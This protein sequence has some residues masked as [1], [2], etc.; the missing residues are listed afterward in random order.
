MELRSFRPLIILFMVVMVLLFVLLIFNA[1]NNDSSNTVKKEEEKEDKTKYPEVKDSPK[2]IQTKVYNENRDYYTGFLNN[3]M[4]HENLFGNLREITKEKLATTTRM[5][6]TLNSFNVNDLGKINCNSIAWN[7]S[8]KGKCGSS[9][10]GV[11]YYIPVS[12]FNIRS[13][14][15]FNM[16]ID[17]SFLNIDDLK[18]GTCTGPYSDSYVFR[19]IKDQSIFVSMKK[20]Y[21]CKNNGI[22]KV[23]D[24]SKTQAGKL[25]TLTVSYSKMQANLV[26]NKYYYGNPTNHQDKFFFDVTPNG[27]YYFKA[28]TLIR[29]FK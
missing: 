1:I 2:E 19:Y 9:K 10:D 3:S 18:I 17:Y 14:E 20:D 29:D 11:A 12:D 7:S 27:K 25:L 6:I 21:S 13:E 5:S 15:I 23:T 28:S 22:L 4:E 16:K 8:W 26:G 24:V